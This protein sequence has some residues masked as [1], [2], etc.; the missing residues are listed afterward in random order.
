MKKIFFLSIILLVVISHSNQDSTD[1]VIIK[2][3]TNFN[4]VETGCCYNKICDETSK[5]KRINKLCYSL[6]GAA[7]FVF[8]VLNFIYFF[9]KI[10]KT[11]KTVLELKKLDDKIYSKKKSSSIEIL[12]KLRNQ[13]NLKI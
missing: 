3:E 5:C 13:Q 11:R 4:C 7:G 2:C 8:I 10:K 6:V 1:D 12:R 9:F